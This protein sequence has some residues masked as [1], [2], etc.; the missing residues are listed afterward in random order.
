MHELDPQV[1]EIIEACY[2]KCTPEGFNKFYADR[3]NY[4]WTMVHGDM[5]P[6]NFV[7]DPKK[8]LPVMIDMEIFG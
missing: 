6:G 8:K 7:Y 2:A 4:Q 1:L 3:P 5:H